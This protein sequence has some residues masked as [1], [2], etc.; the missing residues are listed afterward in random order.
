MECTVPKLMFIDKD[1]GL[2]KALTEGQLE[3]L[4]S[5]GCIA[6]ERGITIRTCSAQGH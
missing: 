3:V 1:G 2:I 4:S 5:D 6:Q